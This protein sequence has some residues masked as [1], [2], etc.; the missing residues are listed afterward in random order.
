MRERSSEKRGS[1]ESRATSIIGWYTSGRNWVR[2]LRRGRR[3]RAGESNF[4][5]LV[6]TS[7]SEVSY[8]SN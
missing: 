4:N 2:R 5:I 7:T 8:L 3:A 1:K 6:I